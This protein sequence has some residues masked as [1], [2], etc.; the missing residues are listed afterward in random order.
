MIE[1][2]KIW[3][4]PNNLSH[5][6]FEMDP[7]W[8]DYSRMTILAAKAMREA[9]PHVPLVLGGISPIDPNFV[10]LMQAE[11]VLDHVDA[12]AIHGFPLDWNHWKLEEWPE[13]IKEIQKVTKLPIWITEVGASSFGS[14]EVQTLGL[15]RTSELLLGRADRIF[16]YSLLDLPPSW[17]ATTRHK[18]VEGSSYYR[19]FYMGLIRADGTPKPAF[20]RF[21]PALG[22]CQWFHFEDPRLEQAVGWMKQLGIRKLRTGISWADWHR[23]NALEWFDRQ[24]AALQDFDLTV[25]LCFTPPSRG[26]RACHTSP[27]L[28]PEEFAE[29]AV[30]VLKRYA[31]KGG[32][33]HA[34]DIHPDSSRFV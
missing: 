13:K 27:P 10:L 16:W 31:P 6:D 2:I 23:P 11:G 18:E 33:H 30:Q 3:N 24:M 19:H 12:V 26:K 21:N 15:E 17:P 1:A 22:I 4:E 20:D 28:V 32:K 29:F 25:T 7:G 5:W 9:A 14:E 34:C 8:K